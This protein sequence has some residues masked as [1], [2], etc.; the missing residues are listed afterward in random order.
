MGVDHRFVLAGD[1]PLVP[2]LRTRMRDAVF[3]GSLSREAVARTFASSDLFVFP[4]KTDTAGHVV[5]E[6]QASG[7]PVVISGDGGARE[8]VI[9][10][11]TGTV[12][13]R[14]DPDEWAG[15]VASLLRQ[16]DRRATVGAAAR[17][18]ARGRTWASALQPLF[19]MYRDVGPP[20]AV[21]A[22]PEPMRAAALGA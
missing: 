20:P 8:N 7:L 14:D 9:S 6:A 10:G 4:S 13:H 1:G 15:A 21:P 12:C 2:E 3:T 17:D 18:Y 19:R 16:G 5:L 22:T 11:R